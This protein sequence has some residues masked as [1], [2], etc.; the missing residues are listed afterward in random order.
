MSRLSS[1][2][3]RVPLVL[4]AVALLLPLP[5][6]SSQPSR[7]EQNAAYCREIA[8]ILDDLSEAKDVYVDDL[9][10]VSDL[11][12]AM[13]IEPAHTMIGIATDDYLLVL[14]DCDYRTQAIEP[15]SHFTGHHYLTQFIYQ[16]KLAAGLMYAGIVT[17]DESGQS[18]ALALMD[19]ASEALDMYAV[20]CQVELGLEGI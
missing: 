9:G 18:E 14:D 8:P 3:A 5:G 2:L 1:F 17:S 13:L 4:I 12:S 20:H 6:C 10:L 15:P 7:E 11:L 16:N 19:E